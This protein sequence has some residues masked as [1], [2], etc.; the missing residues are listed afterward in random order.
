MFTYN[1]VGF[2]TIV[3]SGLGLFLYGIFSI[4]KVLKRMANKKLRAIIDKCSSNRFLGFLVGTGF[5]A[6]IQSSSGT[7]ALAIGLVRAGVMTLAQ[8]CAIIIGAN[9]GTTITAF[10]ISIPVTQYLPILVLVGTF[11]L[12][13]VTRKRSIDV[14]ELIFSLGA[15]FFGLLLMESNLKTLANEPAFINIFTF[16]VD[17]PWLGLLIGTVLTICLQSS[18]AVIGIMQGLYAASMMASLATGNPGISLFG[19]LPIIFGANIGTT[20]TAILTSIGGSKDSKRVAFFHVCY[21][22]IGALIF[23]GLTYIFKKFLLT[24]PTWNIEAKIQLALCHLVFNLVSAFI[25]LPLIKPMIKLAYKLIPG[26]DN[27]NPFMSIKELDSKVMKQFP[28]QGLSLAKEQIITMFK[29]T[30]LMFE[31]LIAYLSSNNHEDSELVHQLEGTVDRFDRQ[32]NDYLLLADKGELSTHEMTSFTQII[33]S[34]KDIE[35]IGDYA[36]NLI[37]FFE[38]INERK[39]KINTNKI[40]ILSSYCSS[41]LSL[42]NKTIEVYQDENVEKAIEIIQLRRKLNEQ[43]DKELEKHCTSIESG[44]NGALYIDLIYYD[45]MNCFQRVNSHCSNIAKL[46][47]SDKTYHYEESEEQHFARLKDRY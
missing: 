16:L 32:L 15:I 42:I 35:R 20:T 47:G 14:A 45:I 46:F 11:I 22:V 40:D 31:T 6:V 30:K 24:S 21:N 33:R 25:F 23:M 29:C 44:K 13:F 9:V 28:S 3:L 5:T 34:C 12:M 39:E 10:I 2:W 19:I 1:E 43:I 36:D 17:Y 4:S 27:K 41:S 8:A 26:K 7:S 18:S 38:N 37:G